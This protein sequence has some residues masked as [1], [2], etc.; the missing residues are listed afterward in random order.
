MQCDGAVLSLVLHLD[1]EA[2]Q[3]AELALERRD[4]GIGTGEVAGAGAGNVAAGAGAGL[5][6][7]RA[8]FGLPDRQALGDDL[9]RQGFGIVRRGYGTGVSIRNG[10]GHS[11]LD[12]DLDGNVVLD[13]EDLT[14]GGGTGGTANTWSGNLAT[15]SSP[16]AICLASS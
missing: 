2:E 14:S 12:N 4:V 8:F 6:A 11:V 10:S 1:L 9:S 7:A 15:T 13:C 5:L 3:I 16:T